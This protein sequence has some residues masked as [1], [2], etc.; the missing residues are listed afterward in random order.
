MFQLMTIKTKIA[1]VFALMTGTVLLSLSAF[2]YFLS[3]QR[4]HD[5]FLGRLKVRAS[6]AADSH[7]H[8]DERNSSIAR[9]LRERHLQE[10]PREKEFYYQD[11]AEMKS[12]IFDSFPMLPDAFIDAVESGEDAVWN[13]GFHY[14]YSLRYNTGDNHSLVIASAYDEAAEEHMTYLRNLLLFGFVTS[15]ILVF[16]LGRIIA[17]RLMRPMTAIISGVHNI[18]ATNLHERLPLGRGDDDELKEI[19]RTF[20]SMLDR[21]ET[22]FEL[23][24]NFIGNASHELRTPLT[25]ILGEADVVLQSD[26][27]PEEYVRSIHVMYDEARKL[28]E[29]TTSLL[30]LSQISYDGKKQK[31]EPLLIDELLMSI[32]INLGRRIPD[33]HVRILVQPVDDN[34]EIFMLACSEVWM[35]LALTN[36]IQNSIK[37][38]DNKEVLVTL[39]AGEEDF[40][41]QI[42][43]YGIGIPEEDIAHILEPFFRGSNTTRYSG[44]GIGLPLAERI[45]RLHGGKMKVSSRPNE[46]TKVSIQFPQY[47]RLKSY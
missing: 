6:L 38:S 8:I 20:N 3:L 15:S 24:S 46:G 19:A 29:V 11:I 12:E 25:A 1:F 18:T 27:S 10:L 41:I 42:S 35:E 40:F 23:Q 43:D 4:A 47:K 5:D 45:I 9:E 22:A 17:Y 32:K 16:L 21:L 14:I 7:F 39:S 28:E 30:R 13:D 36:I 44:Y 31:I 33:N 26:R 34:P 37:Y 2:V